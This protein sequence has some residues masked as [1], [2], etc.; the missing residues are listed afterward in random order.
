[1]SSFAIVIPIVALFGGAIRPLLIFGA[2][3]VAF[4]RVYVGVHYPSDV[5]VGMAVGSL[6]AVMV[7]SLYRR[8]LAK[9]REAS[10]S[11]VLLII[12]S[13]I[14]VFRIYYIFTGPLDL[15]PDEAQYWDWARR[16]DLSYYSKG[17]MIAY[18]I[19]VGRFFFGDTVFGVRV[20]AVILSA[21]SSIVIFF[22]TRRMFEE[23]SALYSAVLFQFIPLFTVF[24][25]IMTIDAPFVFFWIMSLYLVW[26]ISERVE[27]SEKTFQIWILLGVTVGMGLLSKYTMALFYICTLIYM[28]SDRRLRPI[29]KKPYPYLAFVIS[30]IIFSP[31]IIWNAGHDWVTLRHTVGQTHINDGLVISLKD[32]FEFTGSQLGVVTPVLFI[33]FFMA[34]FRMWRGIR[35]KFIF[36]FSMPVF[37]FFLLKSI[38]GKVEAN[39]AMTAYITMITAF[40]YYYL[41]GFK[42]LAKGTRYLVVFGL[43]L[44]VLL[45]VAAH[46]PD[47]LHLPP[48]KNPAVRL[49]GWKEIGKEVSKITGR[50]ADKGKFFIFSNS[51]QVTSELAFYVKGN[52]VTYCANTG[53]RMNQYD[54]WPGFEDM[55]NNNAVFVMINDIKMPARLK[56]AFEKCDRHLYSIRR[57]GVELRRYSIFECYGFKGME[58]P[59]ISSY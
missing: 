6:S 46:Y 20:G 37:A 23:E 48:D 21:L 31:V 14:S 32:F 56:A 19:A 55:V 26:L 29:L 59:G 54:L 25:V 22:M 41:K 13:V 24:G 50:M 12:L 51:Y 57:K 36:W 16:L 9:F 40:S 53:R 18:L 49:M 4:S 38:Q 43:S 39:W 3:T 11:S 15:S 45:T 44:A 5:L 34:V 2:L 30:L 52:P 33:L 1:A 28:L 35:G 58:R 8:G 47:V 42:L 7:M 10:Y 17:P 27:R